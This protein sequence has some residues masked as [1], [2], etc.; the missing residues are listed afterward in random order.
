MGWGWW[1][2]RATRQDASSVRAGVLGC[3]Q[4]KGWAGS[5]VKGAATSSSVW[6]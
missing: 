6:C 4:E 5:Q 2:R 1:E 3:V